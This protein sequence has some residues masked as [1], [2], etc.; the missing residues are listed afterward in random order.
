ME[1][2][3]INLPQSGKRV[4]F[5]DVGVKIF[6]L[7]KQTKSSAGIYRIHKKIYQPGHLEPPS[8]R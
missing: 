1:N 3:L 8:A 4:L 7:G 6:S 2:L 5:K